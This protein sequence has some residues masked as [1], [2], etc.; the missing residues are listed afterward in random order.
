[1]MP[2]LCL[3]P[4]LCCVRRIDLPYPLLIVSRCPRCDGR[5]KQA[6]FRTSSV[7]S[8]FTVALPP[9]WSTRLSDRTG[10]S[11]RWHQLRCPAARRLARCSRVG[12]HC[13]VQPGI[14]RNMS[15]PSQWQASLRCCAAHAGVWLLHSPRHQPLRLRCRQCQRTGTPGGLRR[16]LQA[17]CCWKR[18]E[19]SLVAAATAAQRLYAPDGATVQYVCGIT[20]LPAAVRQQ[21]QLQECGAAACQV[22]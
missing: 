12:A 4:W 20:A 2:L 19:V 3:L 18:R 7:Q 13:R 6:H 15:R 22:M 14:P 10:A 5:R 11:L 16:R 8:I 1:M 9:A 17:V 21:Q